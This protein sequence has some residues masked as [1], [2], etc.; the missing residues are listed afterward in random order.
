MSYLLLCNRLPPPPKNQWFKSID[1]YYFMPFLWIRRPSVAWL[2]GSGSVSQGV[3]VKML[4]GA[5]VI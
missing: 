5:A 1:T 4:I 2:G 3:T